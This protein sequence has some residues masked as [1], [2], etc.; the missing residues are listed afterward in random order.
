[1]L[2]ASMDVSDNELKM[3]KQYVLK[4]GKLFDIS[5]D[6]RMSVFSYGK[7]ARNYLPINRGT[8]IERIENG[9]KK[10][11]STKEPRHIGKA[12]M[13]VYEYIGSEIGSEKNVPKII[14][15]FV[16]GKSSTSDPVEVNSAAESLKAERVVISVVDIGRSFN[17][18]EL[19]Q[20]AS[21][22]DNVARIKTTEDLPLVTPVVSQAFKG[23]PKFS[24]K[25]DLVFVL[26]ASEDDNSSRF[27]IGKLV[28]LEL[29]KRLDFSSSKT[30]IGLVTYGAEAKKIV[31]LSDDLDDA[32]LKSI[33][34]NLE[35]PRPGFG[36][37]K[38][39]M[40]A[41]TEILS[42]RLGA[43]SEVPKRALILLD[44]DLEKNSILAVE[45]L[46]RGGVKV[47]GLA[48]KENMNLPELK[49]V[50]SSKDAVSKVT[51]N[52]DIPQ[53]VERILKSLQSGL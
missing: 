39:I 6:K 40:S 41:R 11:T 33:I 35:T 4:L 10:I 53:S 47:I 49:V 24:E 29:L 50:S 5:N 19:N 46:E 2:D 8:S 36:L 28:I 26:G 9:V 27:N 16:K 43:R 52:E 18:D 48:L 42:E 12:L 38:A 3:M 23:S 34:V 1:M 7:T 22:K 15:L 31:T 51:K 20:I 21:S 25:L 17:E 37:H 13:V 30:K 44:R 14:V 32:K 45:Q